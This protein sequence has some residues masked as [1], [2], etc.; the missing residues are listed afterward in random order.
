MDLSIIIVN[1]NVKDLLEKCLTSIYKETQDIDFE[2]I[3]VDNA[4]AD[5]SVEMV[6]EKFPQAKLIANKENK[7][8]AGGNNQGLQMAQG[9]LILL[10]N[11][12][13]VV[14]DGAVDKMV[15]VM[16]GEEGEDGREGKEGVDRQNN[17]IGVLGCKLLNPDMTI[18]PSCRRLPSL[19]SQIL[20]LLKLHNFFPRLKSIKEYYMSDYQYDDTREVEQVM[21]ACLMV[22]KE[23]VAQIGGLDEKYG[24]IFEEVDFCQRVNYIQKPL[25][26]PPLKGE[27]TRSPSFEEGGRGE[28]FYKIYFT[29]KAEIIHHKG[30]SFRQRKIITNQKNFNYALLRYFRKYK[31]F[32]QYLI[33]VS[34]WPV[35]MSL[36]G[37]DQLMI[38]TGIRKFKEKF[39]KR[40]Y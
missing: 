9:D 24:S 31:P 1:W 10:L 37:A 4:S 29:D 20:I 5:G 36:A 28:V 2:V 8:F 21:G 23:V 30:Q 6:K 12:D 18:Q 38:L 16:G 13:T 15:E 19:S 32:W 39:K 3:V 26:N 35:S 11:P 17:R 22:R 14:L 34:L 27:G 40:E 33:I 7:W 25:P